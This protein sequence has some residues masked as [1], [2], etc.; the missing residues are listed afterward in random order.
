MPELIKCEI[1]VF[2]GKD[3]VHHEI[4]PR[5]QTVNGQF[6]LEFMKCLREAERRKS[7]EGWRNKI[8]RLHYDNTPAHTSLPIREFL[9]KHETT[10]VP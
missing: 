2:D 9:A 4:V 10:V 5:G 3:V 8:W 6:Y 7:T 1:V